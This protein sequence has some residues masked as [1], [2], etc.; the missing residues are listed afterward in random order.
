MIRVLAPVVLL[1]GGATAMLS[2]S[3][4]DVAPFARFVPAVVRC[5]GVE[6]LRAST[7][8]NGSPDADEVWYYLRNLTFQPTD[9]FARLGDPAADGVWRIPAQATDQEKPLPVRFTV[10]IAYGGRL[11]LRE[12]LLEPAGTGKVGWRLAPGEAERWFK[13]RWIARDAVAALRDPKRAK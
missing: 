8:D 6:V 7:S 5:D 3:R 2:A 10:D 4:T 12:L 11:E 13:H 1:L 9:E